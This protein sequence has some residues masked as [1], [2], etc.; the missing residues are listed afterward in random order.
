MGYR[1]NYFNDDLNKSKSWWYTCVS[2]HKKFRQ[3]DITIDHIIP[4][5]KGGGHSIDNLQCMCRSCNSK[6]NN[7]TDNSIDHYIKNGDRRLN[8]GIKNVSKR[9]LNDFDNVLS[10]GKSAIS[11]WLKK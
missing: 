4:Q 11:K 7:H 2:C 5:S 10:K 9:E 8:N 6:K 1:K 3:G